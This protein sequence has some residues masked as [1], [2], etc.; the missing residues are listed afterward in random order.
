[1]I[2]RDP[3]ESHRVATT[4]ELLFDLTFVV[5]I[6]LCGSQLAHAI[7]AGHAGTGI[8]GFALTMFGILWAWI[9]YTWF[10]S[11]FD[12]DD[13]VM[14]IATLVQMVG[15][16]ILALGQAP[17]F[18][19]LEHGDFDCRVLVAGYVVMRVSM[20]YLWWR[21]AAESPEYRQKGR[22]HARWVIGAQVLWIA[23]A[24]AAPPLAWALPACLVAIAVEFL[25]LYWVQTRAGGPGTP[26]HPHHVAE[27]YGLLVII[28]LGEVIL[29]TTT[30][31]DALVDGQGWTVDAAVVA[32]AGVALS[33]AVWW[34]YFAIP[35]GDLL[36][37]QRSKSFGFGY[38]HMPL[39]GAIAAIGAGLHV[40][41]Y[42]VEGEATI[43]TTEVILAVAAPVA[44]AVLGIQLFAAFMMPRGRAMH[45]GLAAVT[46]FV[47][48]GAVAAVMGGLPLAWGI[49]MVVL[50][51]WTAVVAYERLGHAHLV[52]LLGTP[53]DHGPRRPVQP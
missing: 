25:G 2:G 24:V 21:V 28:A 8:L 35:W 20:V 44:L 22:A 6:S 7:A 46:V 34:G 38:G 17:T 13:W 23:L 42:S 43:G 52:E 16:I 4:L 9:N 50:S 10:A 15:V 29:G 27:R 18:A 40:V 47:L 19:A 37:E 48:V 14:R 51:P 32:F 1:M 11:A 45:R 5:A 36:S 39:Y 49:G 33:V 31:V 41:A 53:S 30:A 3:Q 12:T 26:W